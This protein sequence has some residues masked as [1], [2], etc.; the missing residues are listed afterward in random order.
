LRGGVIVLHKFVWDAS[1][2]ELQFLIRFQKKA[3][4]IFKDF[5]LNEDYL[6][7]SGVNKF[8]NLAACDLI[9]VRL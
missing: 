4:V 6:W 3:S 1:F 5:G 2:N 8:H 9:H 7:D